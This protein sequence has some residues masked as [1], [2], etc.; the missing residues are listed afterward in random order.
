MLEG[1][2]ERRT[3][4]GL[5][6]KLILAAF[7]TALNVCRRPIQIY[8]RSNV[9]FSMMW[10]KEDVTRRRQETRVFLGMHSCSKE[11]EHTSRLIRLYISRVSTFTLPAASW[12]NLPTRMIALENRRLC[13]RYLRPK[14][15]Q[16]GLT[17]DGPTSES[18]I[19]A[20]EQPISLH[21]LSNV[22][23][24]GFPAFRASNIL[25]SKIDHM[26]RGR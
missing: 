24:K 23:G 22:Q 13:L 21:F 19:M 9:H 10:D 25:H 7:N 18:N 1:S 3:T 5:C 16:L 8:E 14:E 15:Y 4:F 12:K 11:A 17:F 6:L 2:L 26:G 20:S